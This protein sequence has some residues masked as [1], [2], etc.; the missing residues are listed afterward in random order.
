MAVYITQDMRGRDVSDAAAYGDLEI[1]IPEGEQVYS[2][3]PTVKKIMRKLMN[4]SDDDYLLLSGDPVVIGIAC[5]L[6]ARFNAG[7]V[8]VLKWD[9]LKNQYVPLEIN[10][11]GGVSGL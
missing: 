7:R 9:R 6:A 1:I 3:Q 8:K 4:F 10:L 5:A 11:Y 2:T